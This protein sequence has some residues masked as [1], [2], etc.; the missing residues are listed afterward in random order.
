[1]LFGCGINSILSDSKYQPGEN[2][3][4]DMHGNIDNLHVMDKFVNDFQNKRKSE[5][6]IVH[7]TTEGDPIL[8]DLKYDRK[9]IHYAL[10]TTRDQYGNGSITTK[11]CQS[12]GKN[13][14]N[15]E[16]TYSLQCKGDSEDSNILY[17]N[18]DTSKEDYF[19]FQLKYGVNMKNEV[20]TRAKKL[21]KDLQN[22]ETSVVNDFQFTTD[23]LNKIYKSMKLAGFLENKALKT[24]CNKKPYRSYE[25]TIWIN[26]AEKHHKWTECDHSQDG[27]KMKQMVQEILG[28]LQQNNI[29]K[30][31]PETKGY[32]E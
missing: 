15:V 30:T 17:I 23:E 29:Y 4:V 1:M 6:R 18:Y 20:N 27:V 28:V 25:I 8:T 12:I 32:Y 9:T 14:T 16:M 10:D 26:D 31:L 11:Q 22:G 5:V 13:E 19:E 7:Y 24:S 3:V 2:D 21:V